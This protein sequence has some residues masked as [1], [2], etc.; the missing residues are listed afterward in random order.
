MKIVRDIVGTAH[1]GLRVHRWEC[2]YPDC[3]FVKS[4]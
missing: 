1:G 2:G 3:G 4:A